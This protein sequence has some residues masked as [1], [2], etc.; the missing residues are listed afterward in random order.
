M[1]ICKKNVLQVLPLSAIFFVHYDW[2]R[3]S[4]IIQ[5]DRAMRLNSSLQAM[6]CRWLLLKQYK[7]RIQQ[8]LLW[9]PT[10]TFVDISLRCAPLFYGFSYCFE[11]QR[12]QAS[13]KRSGTGRPNR[14]LD[15]ADPLPF[16]VYLTML[17]LTAR[18]LQT[19]NNIA[20]P[21][22]SRGKPLEFSGSFF[23][24]NFNKKALHM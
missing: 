19:L 16:S 23:C 13:Q 2:R 1:Y 21:P 8:T 24:P 12:W 20:R 18:T 22:S 17:G 9:L 5:R 3:K 14:S 6:F 15:I 10:I 4:G 7:T 11:G